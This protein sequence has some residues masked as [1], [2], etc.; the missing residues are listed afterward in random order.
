MFNTD[1]RRLLARSERE[2]DEK[3]S[4]LHFAVQAPASSRSEALNIPKLVPVFVA[5]SAM[6]NPL[7]MSVRSPQSKA[8]TRTPW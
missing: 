4:L 1:R 2:S 3:T 5:S 6:S 7:L 8:A